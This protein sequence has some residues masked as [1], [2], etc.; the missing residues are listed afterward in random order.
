MHTEFALLRISLIL[1]KLYQFQMVFRVNY[2]N[3]HSLIFS[4]TLLQIYVVSDDGQNVN[5]LLTTGLKQLVKIRVD[6]DG[7]KLLA[8]NKDGNEIRNYDLSMVFEFNITIPSK[9]D[10]YESYSYINIKSS[11]FSLSGIKHRF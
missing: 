7:S 4:L 9:K 6:S 10:K 11:K 1:H 2:L 8:I 5:V 3:E